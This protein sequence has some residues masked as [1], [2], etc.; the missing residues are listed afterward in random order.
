MLQILEFPADPAQRDERAAL[1]IVE[2]ES[3]PLRPRFEP[4]GQCRRLDAGMS[5]AR[6]AVR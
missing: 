2:P 3:E 1:R 6:A 5:S 4:G